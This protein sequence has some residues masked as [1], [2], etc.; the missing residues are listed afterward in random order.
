M[1]RRKAI[2]TQSDVARVIRAAKQAGAGG[3]QILPDGTMFVH[4]EPVEL[5][6]EV[7]PEKPRPHRN[8]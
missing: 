2:I 8:F 6:T 4:L 5:P 3:V 7:Q 1:P